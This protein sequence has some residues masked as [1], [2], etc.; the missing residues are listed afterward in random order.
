MRFILN[1]L[2]AQAIST[3]N[4][5]TGTVSAKMSRSF[6]VVASIPTKAWLNGSTRHL[7]R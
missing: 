5:Q 2:I 7:G 3:Y 6:Q 1:V 4:F